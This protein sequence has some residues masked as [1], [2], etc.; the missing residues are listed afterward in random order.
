[1]FL[2]FGGKLL[3]FILFYFYMQS[4]LAWLVVKVH[5]WQHPAL[6]ESAC[7]V[8]QAPRRDRGSAQHHLQRD[9]EPVQHCQ[10][11]LHQPHLWNGR[12]QE[13]PTGSLGQGE[14]HDTSLISL[15]CLNTC[16]IKDPK[17]WSGCQIVTTAI[18][19]EMWSF[20]KCLHVLVL[21][22]SFG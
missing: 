5:R 9:V 8:T 12:Y 10:R 16:M 1:M 3:I 20:L 7:G 6:S 19:C 21:D 14:D 18:C 4:E 22:H 11:L 2:C 15:P 17:E 13:Q